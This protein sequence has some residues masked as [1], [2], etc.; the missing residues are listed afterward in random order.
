MEQSVKVKSVRGYRSAGAYVCV[1]HVRPTLAALLACFLSFAF[2]DRTAVCSLS[3]QC[4]CVYLH[5][6]SKVRSCT[7]PY[8]Q[9]QP[10]HLTSNLVLNIINRNLPTQEEK[11]KMKTMVFIANVFRLDRFLQSTERMEGKKVV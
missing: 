1:R 8:L 7:P 10:P 2:H 4:G 3:V 5:P 11:K 6:C 9:G